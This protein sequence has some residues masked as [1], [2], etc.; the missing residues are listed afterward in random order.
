MK[1]GRIIAGLAVLV[2]SLV[3][4]SSMSSAMTPRAT[5]ANV[6]RGYKNIAVAYGNGTFVEV[7]YSADGKYMN[8]TAINSTT[9]AVIATN[10]ISQDVYLSPYGKPSIKPAIVYAGDSFIIAWVNS[11]KSLVAE[12]VDSNL[13]TNIN[14]TTINDTTGVSYTNIAIAAGA[15]K[16]LF[17]W[18]DTNN[19]LE[20]RFMNNTY[21]GTVFRITSFNSVSQQTPWVAYDSKT[22]NFMVTWV[23]VTK[24]STGT[25]FYNITGKIFN[26][27][28]MS[29]VTGDILIANA[30]ADQSSYTTPTVA[31]GN[32]T[33]FVTYVTY[34]S[35]YNIH[36]VTYSAS[37]GNLVAGP[38][39]IGSSYKYGRSPMPS[40]YDGT[41]FV[42][43]WSNATE[44]IIATTYDIHGNA[45]TSQVIYNGTNGGNP[46]I[47]YDSDN[48]VYFFSWTE[49]ISHKPYN[50]DASLWTS[51][52]FVPEFNFALPV[53][54]VA[55]VSMAILRRK[56]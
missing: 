16:V 54:A 47:A 9:G 11:N 51:D 20:G 55:L 43:A 46:A 5:N 13:N 22:N 33:F 38:F 42:V 56:H 41:N 30:Y 48:G 39:L 14:E 49:Y 35:P 19:Q 1:T 44:S 27:D 21:N 6:G 29:A 26:G 7:W 31:G 40:V 2:L 28:S 53:I 52:E 50:I 3:V 36:G 25:K 23:N 15:D 4:L 8:A 18:N 17:V 32:G 12:G 45:G 37:D 10:T 24:N 34:L